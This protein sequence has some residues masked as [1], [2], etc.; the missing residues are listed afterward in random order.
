MVQPSLDTLWKITSALNITLF[1]L[2]EQ[3]ESKSVAVVRKEKQKKIEIP[4]SNVLYQLLSPDIN[5][6]I[7]FL[8]L[9]LK[10]GNHPGELISHPGEECGVVIQGTIGIR[11]GGEQYILNQGDSIY[12][13]SSIPHRFYNPGSEEAIGVWAMTPPTF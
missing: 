10:P 2:F 13:D 7:E 12:F 6:K 3:V 4:Q 9:K 5:R 8:M 11:I 1:Y